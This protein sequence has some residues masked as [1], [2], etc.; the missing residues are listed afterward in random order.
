MLASDLGNNGGEVSLFT[1]ATPLAAY[2]NAMTVRASGS[3]SM[4]S[5]IGGDLST[6][7]ITHFVAGDY[8]S[9]GEALRVNADKTNQFMQSVAI[10]S[11][12]AAG[13]KFYNNAGIFSS[14]TTGGVVSSFAGL[15]SG[16][17]TL[18]TASGLSL[19]AQI[20][21]LAL[22]STS[23]VGALSAADWNT[24]NGKQ[25]ALTIGNL[26]DVGTDGIV[27][28]GGSGAVIG[29][30]TSLAQHVADASH[31]GYLS[32]TDWSTF[33]SKQSALTLT[34]LTDAGTDGITIT[35]G[36][37]AVIGASP[38]T[39][40]QHVADASHNGY[41]SS[42]DWSTFNGKQASGSYITALTGDAA[43]SGPGSAAL[44]LAT[45]NS[46]VGTF[47]DA[48]HVAQVT[49]NAKGLITAASSVAI[50]TSFTAPKVTSYTGGS[51]THTFTG[52]PLYV[53]VRMVGAGGG[54]GGGGASSGNGTAGG[55]TT[56]GTSLLVA[57][58]GSQGSGGGGGVGVGGTA[59]LGSGPTGTAV[60]G[61]GGDGV[62]LGTQGGGGA[63]GCSF[64]GG[65]GAGSVPG[66]AGGAAA[67]NSGSGGGGGSSGVATAGGGG[68][69]S[70][71]FVDAVISGS[72]LSGLA[73]SAAYFVGA[74]GS[75]GGAGTS[76]SN[77]GNGAD[78]YIEV[79][80]YYQ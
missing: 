40:A 27:V 55:N 42:T 50:T 71:G 79:T 4:L 5:L 39:I 26:T 56:F 6:G 69:G 24:F 76:G 66:P 64:F 1:S 30:G 8:T 78:G 45:V 41:L 11:S 19:S 59:S 43:A 73:G 44:T 63:G 35:N 9:A 15:N 37:G 74:K 46:N 18:G 25:S 7:Y 62:T 22:S 23:T 10:P 28:T 16:D 13:L 80:E 54:G 61:S 58:G 48:T 17:V 14:K 70:G 47:G 2:A 12:P 21:S 34:N 68:G 51:A 60:S 36:T 38:V 57:N 33:N 20:L 31:N 52:S 75:G 77:G 67:A 3:T 65:A 49:V 29:S 53:R 72:T 32:S